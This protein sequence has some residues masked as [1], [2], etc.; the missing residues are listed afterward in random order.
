V[1]IAMLA[2]IAWRTPPVHYGPWERIA[3]LLTEELVKHGHEVTLFATGNSLTAA[4][5]Q[6]VTKNG[7]EEDKSLDTKV[8]TCLHI[9]NCFEH[10]HEFDIIHNQFDFLPLSYSKLVDTPVVTTIHGFSSPKILPVF[11]KYNDRVFYVSISDADRSPDLDYLATVYHGIDIENFTF[12]EKPRDDYLLFFGRIHHDKGAK[13]AIAIARGSGKRLVMAGIVQDEAYY[14]KNVEPELD[15]GDIEYIGSVG[16][17]K[18]DPLLGHAL[19]L[20]HPIHFDEPFGLSV[21]EAMACGTPV[22]AFNRGSMPEIIEDGYN[23]FLVNTVEQAVRRVRD[24]ASISRPVCR[25]TVENRFTSVRMTDEY[26]TVYETILKK[27]GIKS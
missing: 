7:Y 6:W 27:K 12:Q 17:D 25:Q 8:W 23:G 21:I 14:K 26:I 11:R 3:S 24:I 15:K 4:K 2:P 18:R 20:L 22:I 16:P 1:K 9:A 19:A 10:A 13:E 5:L